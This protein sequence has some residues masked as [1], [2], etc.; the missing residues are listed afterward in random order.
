MQPV[1]AFIIEMHRKRREEDGVYKNLVLPASAIVL[2]R[3]KRCMIVAI[4]S[5]SSSA[6]CMQAMLRWALQKGADTVVPRSK[7]AT[8]MQVEAGFR[9]HDHSLSFSLYSALC[10]YIYISF[11]PPSLNSNYPGAR[12]SRHMIMHA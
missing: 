5:P 1:V 11:L 12:T 6:P 2:L 4:P 10:L 3:G 7:N 9:D 8:H